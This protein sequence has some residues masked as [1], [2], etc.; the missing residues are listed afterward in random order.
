[1]GLSPHARGNPR[2]DHGLS[3]LAGPIPACAGEPWPLSAAS[4][5][6]RAY[7]RMRGGTAGLRWQGARSEGLSPHARGNPRAY[8]SQRLP[9]GPIPACAGEPSL[10]DALRAKQ[11]AYPRMRGGTSVNF[12]GLPP[13]A[14]LS[15]HAR[16]NPLSD[17]L[18]NFNPGPIP[19]CAG[20]PLHTKLP[21]SQ[22]W[23]YPRMRGGTGRSIGQG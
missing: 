18:I 8:G 6:T 20:E 3:G 16:R 4:T 19:A 10:C 13:E 1:M 12:G 5:S 2:R 9:L 21:Q 15:P 17:G 23:A 22:N 14:G 7:P 11:W